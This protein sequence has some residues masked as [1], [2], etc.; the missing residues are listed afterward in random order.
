MLSSP[1]TALLQVGSPYGRVGC[2]ARLVLIVRWLLQVTKAAEVDKETSSTPTSLARS[3]SRT[4]TLGG[5]APPRCTATVSHSSSSGASSN[6]PARVAVRWTRKT[7]TSQ[8]SFI[9]CCAG[10]WP[11]SGA[12]AAG[13][14]PT[15]IS[16]RGWLPF[17]ALV[18]P[19]SRSAP[20]AAPGPRT[21]R[22]RA[23]PM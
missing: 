15:I 1:S 18:K 4:S 21:A 8:A 6:M 9:S 19:S 3:R 14:W 17:P 22:P 13:E 11:T 23:V 5:A 20:G 7:T 2:V 16:T 10:H 12:L